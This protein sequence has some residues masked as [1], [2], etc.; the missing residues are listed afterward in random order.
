MMAWIHNEV[1]SH[2]P[3]LDVFSVDEGSGKTELLGVLGLLT[4]KPCLGAEFTAANVY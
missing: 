4:P 2:S 3:I 1:A